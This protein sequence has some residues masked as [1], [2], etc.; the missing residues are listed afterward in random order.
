MHTTDF[1]TYFGLLKTFET[2]KC[3]TWYAEGTTP[4]WTN[5][6]F[7]WSIRR[8]QEYPTLQHTSKLN[9]WKKV[10]WGLGSIHRLLIGWRQIWIR[11]WGQFK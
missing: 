4:L 11:D 5:Y 8:R 9:Y 7:S 6:F 2:N 10:G 1:L 3:K